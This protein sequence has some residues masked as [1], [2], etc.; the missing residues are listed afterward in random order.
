MLTPPRERSASGMGTAGKATLEMGGDVYSFA[1]NMT[2]LTKAFVTG[3]YV[4]VTA[5]TWG[6]INNVYAFGADG[7]AIAEVGIGK[8]LTSITGDEYYQEA[9]EE[10]AEKDRKID[11]FTDVLKSDQSPKWMQEI[12]KY[13]D[14]LDKAA[15]GKKLYDAGEGFVKDAHEMEKVFTSE[16]LTNETKLSYAKDVILKNMGFSN[17]DYSNDT[18]LGQEK[19]QLGFFDNIKNLYDWGIA[20]GK[21]EGD[22]V[23]QDKFGLTKF[24]KDADEFFED[25]TK[26]IYSWTH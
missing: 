1:K 3:N 6:L 23:F 24:G 16:Q 18:L 22:K 11:G 4:D 5:N 13:T 21:G 17:T 9:F 2:G 14:I 26:M 15:A 25:T 19:N 8:A 10:R 12:G 20:A 7:V